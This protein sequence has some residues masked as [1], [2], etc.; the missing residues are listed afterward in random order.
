MPD[1]P[2]LVH[3]TFEIKIAERRKDG[4]RIIIN[5][6]GL[7]R[8]R[9]RVL[10]I[11]VDANAYLNNPIVQWGHNYS[12]PWATVGKTT[13]IDVSDK[14]LTVDFELRPAANEQDPQNIVKLL[15]EGGWIRTASIGFLPLD[16]KPNDA[17]R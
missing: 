6:A 4:G 15:W 17:G 1:Q 11:G 16:G 12:D 5:T 8:Q 3:K 14:A 7:D 13:R 10:P 9:D 2:V